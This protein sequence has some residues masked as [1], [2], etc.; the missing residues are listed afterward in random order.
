MTTKPI[1]FSFKYRGDHVLGITCLCFPSIKIIGI[2]D[3]L[4]NLI[5]VV[6]TYRHANRAPHSLSF[7]NVSSISAILSNAQINHL[8]LLP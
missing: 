4:C 6:N 7:E 3:I 1:A 5:Q 8:M 2:L